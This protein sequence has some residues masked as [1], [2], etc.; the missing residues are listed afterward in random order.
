MTWFFMAICPDLRR[1]QASDRVFML[2]PISSDWIAQ[3]P[4]DRLT[5]EFRCVSIP[6]DTLLRSG[7]SDIVYISNYGVTLSQH[8][9]AGVDLW[10][11]SESFVSFK[12]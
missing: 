11:N 9:V 4:G 1:F 2:Y 7:N 5:R 3:W 8:M 10:L 12:Y 6:A